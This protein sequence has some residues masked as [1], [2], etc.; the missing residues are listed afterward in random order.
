MERVPFYSEVR[1]PKSRTLDE[2]GFS[3]H[4]DTPPVNCVKV[5]AGTK[6]IGNVA[7]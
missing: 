4:T 2:I 6:A 1:R 7:T 3:K 5:R